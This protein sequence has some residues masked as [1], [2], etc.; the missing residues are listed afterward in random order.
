MAFLFFTGLRCTGKNVCPKLTSWKVVELR[1]HV[2]HWVLKSMLIFCCHSAS[3]G[4]VD[5]FP[6]GLVIWGLGSHR[7]W[8]VLTCLLTNYPCSF[9]LKFQHLEWDNDPLTLHIFLLLPHHWKG[10]MQ[11]EPTQQIFAE[12]Q[13]WLQLALCS[14][15]DTYNL[16]FKVSHWWNCI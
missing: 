11:E 3:L 6:R 5:I 1:F 9:V 15:Q 8:S 14:W 16:L 13:L 7:Y 2:G 4:G 10:L 12:A